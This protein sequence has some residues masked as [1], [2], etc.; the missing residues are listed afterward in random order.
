[1]SENAVD[2]FLELANIPEEHLDK[3]A[4]DAARAYQDEL[5]PDLLET[6]NEIFGGII[7]SA[8]R[9]SD[10]SSSDTPFIDLENE[11]DVVILTFTNGAKV[12][13]RTSEWAWIEK[14]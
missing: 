11:K 12:R 5:I 14:V 7:A 6:A 9:S 1:M 8:E 10:D 4:V 3:Q 2:K 13:F